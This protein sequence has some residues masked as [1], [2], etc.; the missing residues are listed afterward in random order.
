M[1]VFK[2]IITL[3]LGSLGIIDNYLTSMIRRRVNTY[4]ATQPNKTYSLF[5]ESININRYLLY[6]LTADAFM[7]Y[8]APF[9]CINPCIDAFIFD[10]LGKDLLLGSMGLC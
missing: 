2:T 7:N 1:I 3:R 4:I 9:F 5:F 8:K 6:S 10:F